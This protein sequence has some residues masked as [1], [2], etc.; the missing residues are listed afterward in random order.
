MAVL[1]AVCLAAESVAWKAAV[2]A[3]RLVVLMAGLKAV[4]LPAESETWLG[5]WSVGL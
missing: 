1:L 3:G 2:L 4:V 5:V